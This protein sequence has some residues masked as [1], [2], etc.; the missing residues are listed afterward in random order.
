MFGFSLAFL[1]LVGSFHF[2]VSVLVS[3]GAAA[4]AAVSA[5]ALQNGIILQHAVDCQSFLCRGSFL[6]TV[7][8]IYFSRVKRDGI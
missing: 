4:V 2:G 1:G 5:G 8:M 7:K 3:I 6:N